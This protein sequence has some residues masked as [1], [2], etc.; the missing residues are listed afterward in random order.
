[1][2]K[3]SAEVFSPSPE[4][5]L[6]IAQEL[7]SIPSFKGEEAELSQWVAEFL[8]NLGYDV[9]EQHLRPGQS[10]TIARS[11]VDPGRPTVMLNGHLDID[12]LRSNWSQDPFTVRLEGNLLIGAGARN[13]QGGLVSILLAAEALIHEKERANITIALVA[14][15]L[16]GGLG[17]T[18]A[19]ERGLTA[20][21]AIVPEPFAVANL[22]TDTWGVIEFAVILEGLSSHISKPHLAHDPLPIAIDLREEFLRKVPQRFG[23]SDESRGL[24]FNIGGFVAARGDNYSLNAANYSPDRCALL[25]DVRHTIRVSTQEILDFFTGIVGEF[26]ARSDLTGVSVRMESGSTE[27]YRLNEINFPPYSA[28]LAPE[29]EAFLQEVRVHTLGERFQDTGTVY[30]HSYCGADT[31]HMGEAGIP[32]VLVGPIG[33]LPDPKIGDDA[34]YFNEVLDTATY[35]HGIAVRITR[36][37]LGGTQ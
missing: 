28:N 5:A 1:M 20:D 21:L 35:L 4:R 16:Q 31:A 27:H 15:E 8:R 9:E 32:S 30:P 23:A 18:Y 33:P 22:V 17:T 36:E 26:D 29:M 10:Q 37:S 34:V 11:E 3:M 7:M 13:M 19:L 6:E 2:S 25:I 14:G 12:P 24:L